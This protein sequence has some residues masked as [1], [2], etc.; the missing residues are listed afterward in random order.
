MKCVFI[1][2]IELYRRYI[3]PLTPPSCRYYPTCSQ[4]TKTAIER[5][6]SLKGIVM[7]CV[8]L[9]RCHPFVK[10]GVDLVPDTFSIK[11]NTSS[12]SCDNLAEVK[13]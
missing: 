2:M 12:C 10:G 1:Y 3:S 9:L 4:Y 11:R 5:H 6:G 13:E 8:R 7:G